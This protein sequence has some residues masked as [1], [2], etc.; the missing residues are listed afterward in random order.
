MVNEIV[1]DYL[2]LGWLN[3]ELKIE[4]LTDILSNHVYLPIFKLEE[5]ATR[6]VESVGDSDDEE[7][8]AKIV[9]GEI[10]EVLEDVKVLS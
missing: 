1:E 8:I 5:I 2:S 4:Q 10:D 9:R 3:D 7:E 6:I